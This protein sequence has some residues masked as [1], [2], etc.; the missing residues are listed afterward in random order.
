[1]FL[2]E[3]YMKKD[4]KIFGIHPV[5]EALQSDQSIQK[6]IIQ[7]GKHAWAIDQIKTE[8]EKSNIKL[9][10]LPVE[11][12]KKYDHHNHQG[13]IAFLSPVK[14]ISIEELIEKHQNKDQ[15]NYLL[16]DGVTDVRNLGAIIRNAE[17]MNCDVVILP[18]NN[19][20]TINETTIKASAGSI[21]NIPIC[22]VRHLFYELM[23]LKSEGIQ[24]IAIT[25]KSQHNI[26]DYKL[27]EKMAFIIGDEGKG[28]SLK[29]LKA[30]DMKLKIPLTGKTSSLNVS[31]ATGI[32]LY[33]RSKQIAKVNK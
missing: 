16:L 24:C 29:I 17:S 11:G 2:F 13:V 33:E 14:F 12:F 6:V 22:K 18:E 19:S 30:C 23:H 7:K 10:F 31:V 20:A 25:E 21:Y 3:T 28:I 4:N 26:Y 8:T 27:Q 15:V 5:L 9:Q 1:M 32:A